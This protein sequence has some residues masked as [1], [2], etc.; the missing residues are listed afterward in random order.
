MPSTSPDFSIVIRE[1]AAVFMG[2]SMREFNQFLRAASV[3]MPQMMALFRVHYHGPCGVSEI[4]DHL[5]VSRAA[6]SQL[7][8][9]L[10]QQGLLRRWEHPTDRR[11]KLVALTEAGASLVAEGIDARQRWMDELTEVLSLEEQRSI[12]DTLGRLTEAAQQLGAD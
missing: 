8:D 1:W 5:D 9:R 12:A 10:V 11:I 7:V 3:S 2:R 6:A 4:A